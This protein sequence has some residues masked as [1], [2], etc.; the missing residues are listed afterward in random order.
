M[1]FCH[2]PKFFQLCGSKYF[3]HSLVI[4]VKD[5]LHIAVKLW[6]AKVKIQGKTPIIYRTKKAYLGTAHIRK[7]ST[8]S[9]PVDGKIVLFTSPI[10][11]VGIIDDAS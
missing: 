8:T 1:A 2:V 10:A 7:T 3:R 11:A 9:L 6:S 4:R 5:K